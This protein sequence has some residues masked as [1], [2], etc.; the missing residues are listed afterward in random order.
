MKPIN[1]MIPFST[2]ILEKEPYRVIII[3]PIPKK[4]SKNLVLIHSRTAILPSNLK[5][6]ISSDFIN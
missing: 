3:Y 4:W 1:D 2:G 5:K 6:L